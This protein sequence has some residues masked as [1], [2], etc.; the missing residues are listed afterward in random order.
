MN[1][2]I[3]DLGINNLNSI[4]NSLKSINKSNIKIVEKNEINKDFSLLIL[5]GL[6]KFQSGMNAIEERGLDRYI[7]I[8]LE[9]GSC[10]L[11]ICLG[12]QLLG[13]GSQESPNVKGL[14]LIRGNSFKLSTEFG[15][16]IPNVGWA[17]AQLKKDFELF[18]S[19]TLKKDFYFVH[20]FHFLPEDDN[21]ILS[22]TKF[23]S[24]KFVSSIKFNRIVGVQFHPEKSANIGQAFLSDALSWAKNEA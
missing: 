24:S 4:I 23:G 12:M 19:L 10:L 2:E 14:S 17:H 5:P 15:E 20:S 11:G 16:R 22:E 1:V 13:W 8:K 7:R 21:D 3:L 6:G 18:P 9:S